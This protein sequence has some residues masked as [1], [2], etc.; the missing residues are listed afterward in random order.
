MFLIIKMKNIRNRFLSSRNN[1]VI[2]IIVP[3]TA[4]MEHKYH[5]IGD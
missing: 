3:A 5:A 4:I 2:F 1:L